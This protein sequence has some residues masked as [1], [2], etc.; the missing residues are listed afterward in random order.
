MHAEAMEVVHNLSRSATHRESV[1]E[2][3]ELPPLMMKAAKDHNDQ[4]EVQEMLIACTSELCQMETLRPG[5]AAKGAE[6]YIIAA[7][8][9]HTGESP[10]RSICCMEE[11]GAVAFWHM[12]APKRDK[13]F[14]IKFQ[15]AAA[16]CLMKALENNGRNGVCTEHNML[17][18]RKFIDSEGN[19]GPEYFY[20]QNV[21]PLVIDAIHNHSGQLATLVAAT[22]ILKNLVAA[23][24]Y[25]GEDGQV[26][27]LIKT[28]RMV[29]KQYISEVS[30]MKDGLQ[31]F[32]T[33]LAA[34]E[35]AK[36]IIETGALDVL[37]DALREYP[38]GKEGGISAHMQA[39][40]MEILGIFSFVESSLGTSF[41]DFM[42]LVETG[43]RGFRSKMSLQVNGAKILRYCVL[44]GGNIEV[45]LT[46]SRHEEQNKWGAWDWYDHAGTLTS[47]LRTWVKEVNVQQ[48]VSFLFRVLSEKPGVVDMFVQCELV[49]PLLSSLKAHPKDVQVTENIL[50]VIANILS[51]PELAHELVA[52]GLPPVMFRALEEHSDQPT[53][54][55]I[56]FVIFQR[57]V[58]HEPAN[59]KILLESSAAQIIQNIVN[60]YPNEP[61]VQEQ[62][63]RAIQLLFEG[64]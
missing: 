20:E 10:V 32:H 2:E 43:M 58:A 35:S 44:Q 16:P 53:S 12:Q 9:E 46:K 4:V 17:T 51:G 39:G 18:L 14:N 22:N 36:P 59:K 62:G 3:K 7:C 19:G 29:M 37:V 5:L 24:N 11:H 13:V 34:T 45:F 8:L 48:D 30:I 31:I 21:M 64:I 26:E 38:A 23:K 28:T 57:L 52:E 56:I 49:A 25:R 61:A 60:A 63:M 33:L 41:E 6:K 50:A 40:A 1:A 27:Q 42:D 55:M 15:Q 47:A 54:I